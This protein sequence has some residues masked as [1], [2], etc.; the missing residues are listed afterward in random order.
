MSKQSN[1]HQDQSGSNYKKILYWTQYGFVS[2]FPEP[3]GLGVG[4]DVYKRAGCP[5]WQCETSQDRSNLSQ[6]DAILF[7]YLNFQGWDLPPIRF[8][9][10]LYVFFE[11]ESPQF[12]TSHRGFFVPEMMNDFFNWTMSYRWD[13]DVVHPY[14][15]I[16]PNGSIPLHPNKKEYEKLI[17]ETSEVNY[18]AGKTGIAAWMVTKCKSPSGRGE[19]VNKLIEHGIQ[20]DVY[21]ACG[22]MSC[23]IS[24][25]QYG[26]FKTDESDEPCRQLIGAKYKFYFALENALCRDYVTEKYVP[27][28][29]TLSH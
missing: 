3:F 7:H 1:V 16:E 11:Y 29:N 28:I 18:A 5:V 25:Y 27:L 19:L 4:R 24:N 14:G 23:G 13:A 26:T 20:V 9:N 10:Q 6:Y 21:G 22:N 15:W 2:A 12:K 8:Q 17:S